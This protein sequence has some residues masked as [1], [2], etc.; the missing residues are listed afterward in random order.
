MDPD[1]VAWQTGLIPGQEYDPDDL[2]RAL[3]RLRRLQVFN[4]TRIV[5]ADEVTPQGTLP[6]TVQVAERPLHVFGGGASY[7]TEDGAGVEGY[8]EHRNLFGRAE[9]LRFEG[10]VA[11]IDS[12]DPRDFI[13]FAA[14][15]FIKPGVFTPTTDLIATISASRDVYDPYIQNTFRGRIGFAHEFFEGL[16][17]KVSAN[18]EYDQVDDGFGKRD[19]V[20]ASLPS[21]IAYDG[22]DDKLEPTTGYRVKLSVEPFHEFRFENT[23]VFS[24]IDGSTYFSFDEDGRYVLAVRAAARGDRRRAG[25]RTAGRPPLLRGRRRIGARLCLSLA[26]PAR[27]RTARSSA[28]CRSPRPRSRCAC[29]SPTRSAS[30]P[31]STRA[32]PSPRTFPT[33]RRS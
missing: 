2:D 15:T 8:W 11:G 19:L 28:A 20:L 26:R 31:S 30:C 21:E 32:T 25:R 6:L 24:R 9:R 5:E 23:G 29:A 12:T 10:R 33:S 13:Y 17:A 22:T 1:F 27:C 4:S 7:S 16:T 18:G 14:C 3:R